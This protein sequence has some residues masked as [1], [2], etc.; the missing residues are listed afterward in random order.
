[1]KK[2]LQEKIPAIF[3]IQK[4][5][6]QDGDG[7]R[8][9]VFFKGCPLRCAWCH[10]PEGIYSSPELLWN[11]EKCVFCGR[12]VLAAGEDSIRI[13]AGRVQAA[14]EI[15]AQHIRGVQACQN[16]ALEIAGEYYTQKELLRLL[17]QDRMFYEESGGG[18]T[19]SGGEVMAA[20]P[21]SYVVSMAQ[22]LW[23]E[24]IPLY[25]DTSGAA[26][27][28]RFKEIMPY[29]QTFLYD[30]KCIDEKKHRHFIGTGNAL[31][32]ENAKRLYADGARIFLRL[33]FIEG[34]NTEKADVAALLNFLQNEVTPARV[35]LLPYHDMGRDKY[36]RLGQTYTGGAFKAPSK[37]FLEKTQALLIN[38]GIP[39]V[40]I[41][42][43][44]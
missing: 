14:G 38:N 30:I 26:A 29:T 37:D 3:H 36:T 10:N 5:S 42:G 8:T 19:F 34:I 24:G 28:S 11:T 6:L 4:Y 16:Q 2:C 7:I 35:Y 27:Y 15:N 18:V 23:E 21:F 1:M 33:P 13:L 32:L 25:I 31:I 41:G 44:E 43:S 40:R 20:E 12:C 22:Q 39:D 17:L 9:T